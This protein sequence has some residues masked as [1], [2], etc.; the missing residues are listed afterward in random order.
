MAKPKSASAQLAEKKMIK[1]KCETV[2]LVV[3]GFWL[4]NGTI[5]RGFTPHKNLSGRL[6]K[7]MLSLIYRRI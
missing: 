4:P 6:L 3:S 1:D 7:S 2:W 5:E